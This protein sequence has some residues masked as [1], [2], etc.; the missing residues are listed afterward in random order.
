MRRGFGAAGLA[1]RKDDDDRLNKLGQEIRDERE[2][3]V[4][5]ALAVLKDK[6]RKFSAKYRNQI[7]A[8]PELC[9]QFLSV[10]TA[11]GLDPLVSDRSVWDDIFGGGRFLPEVSV[12]L[13]KEVSLSRSENGGVME[14]ADCV[15]KINTRR[16][17]GRYANVTESDITRCVKE[18]ECFGQGIMWIEKI[19]KVKFIFY[20]PDEIGP[21]SLYILGELGDKRKIA[22]KDLKRLGWSQSRTELALSQLIRDG[23][24]WVDL[25]ANSSVV[26]S[27]DS[28]FYL[29]P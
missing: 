6:L 26:L 10:C 5:A 9:Q 8:D 23:I 16:G 4:S 13:L 24:I 17:G 18:L 15:R 14:L 28:L 1:K 12:Q 21:D 27:N 29:A 2:E 7:T 20:S 19:N 3:K 25:N 22:M 11:I